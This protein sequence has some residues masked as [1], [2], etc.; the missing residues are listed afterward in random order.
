MKDYLKNLIKKSLEK[1]NISKEISEIAI[2]IP[3]KKGFGDYSSNVALKFSKGSNM[4]SRELANEIINNINDENIAKMEVAGPGFINFYLKNDYL[5]DNLNKII[6]EDDYGKSNIGANKKINIEYVS[7]NPTGILH[8]GHARGAAYGDALSRIMKFAGYDVTREY[9]INDG[10]NQIN[11]LVNSIKA[12]YDEL[13]GLDVTFPEDGYHGVEIIDLAKKIY[14]KYP[15]TVDMEVIKEYGVNYL[16]D[17]IKNDLKNFNVEFDVW[18]S[19]KTLYQANAVSDV[20]KK[21]KEKNLTYESEGA[22]WLKTS[23]YGDEKDHVLIKKDG[24]Y[25]YLIPD[26]AYHINKFSR[27]FDELIDVFGAD[28]HGYIPRL[29]ASLRMLGYDDSK[30]DFEI[31]QMV[32]LL[33]NGEEVKMSKRTGK[34]VTMNELVSDVGLDATRYI[35]TSRSLDTQ[36]DFDMDIATKHNNENPVYYV[37][38]AYARISSI[39]NEYGKDI[40]PMNYTNLNSEYVL[41]LLNKMYEFKDVIEASATRHMPHLLTNYVYDLATLFH[42][43]YAHEHVLTGDELKTEEYI[44][45]IKAVSII[46]KKS[47]NLIGVQAYE[48]M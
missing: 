32:R 22:I 43:F 41:D 18:F 47:L 23:E 14:E 29:K 12:R 30:I 25:T 45:L 44:N 16:L 40:K 37:Q 46:I 36:L 21:L 39:L 17:Q 8:L 11:N 15:D 3:N 13:K 20:I 33:K 31:L 34:V 7:A 42:V 35:F 5:Y 24:T 6:T 28:H 4:N 10:G 1:M 38:Y 19:E 27:N 2:E 26:I 48:K 9:Y